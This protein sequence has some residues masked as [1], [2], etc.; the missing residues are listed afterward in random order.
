MKRSTLAGSVT[1]F[2]CLGFAT[3]LFAAEPPLGRRRDPTGFQ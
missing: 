2:F 3:T 1:A